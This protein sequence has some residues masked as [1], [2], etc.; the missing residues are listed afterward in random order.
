MYKLDYKFPIKQTHGII[1]DIS[2]SQTTVRQYLAPSAS[3][4]S[5]QKAYDHSWR[6]LH[7][8]RLSPRPCSHCVSCTQ[9]ESFRRYQQQLHS[10][11][12]LKLIGKRAPQPQR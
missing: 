6:A 2:R 10:A 4:A 5:V 1:L 3:R 7:Q 8:G 12:N 11:F 9:H